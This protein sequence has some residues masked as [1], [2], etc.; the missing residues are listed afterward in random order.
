[1]KNKKIRTQ[2]MKKRISALVNRND[3]GGTKKSATENIIP[4]ILTALGFLFSYSLAQAMSR[5]YD[6]LVT[7]QDQKKK[8][9]ILWGYTIVVLLSVALAFVFLADD[10]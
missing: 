6:T 8:L 9:L 1:M 4:L 7:T 2:I 3:E 10:F 5:T